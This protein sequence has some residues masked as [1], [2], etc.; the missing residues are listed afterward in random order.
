LKGVKGHIHQPMTL[1]EDDEK[2][3]ITV[4]PCGSGGRLIAMEGYAEGSG[5]ARIAEPHNIT[6][7]QADFPIY[8]VPASLWPRSALGA[9]ESSTSS[10][11]LKKRPRARAASIIS[12]KT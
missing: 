4:E 11:P 2:V 1:N 7:Q 3:T 6:W 9:V 5:L 12:T 8:C 10:K